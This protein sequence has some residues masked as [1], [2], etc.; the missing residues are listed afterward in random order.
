MSKSHY[1]NDE[2]IKILQDFYKEHSRSPMMKDFKNK[3]PSA[4]LIKC[5][6]GSWNNALK[7][8][9]LELNKTKKEIYT[10]QQLLDFLKEFYELYGYVPT[11]R[12]LTNKGYPTFYAYKKHFGSFKNALIEAGLFDL[13]ED[14]HQFCE[15]YTDEELLNKLRQFMKG[16]DYIPTY[17]EMRKEL[18]PSVSTYD[19]RFNGVFNALKLI[20]YDVDK[21]KEKEVKLIEQ[22]MIEKYK[23]L[24]KMLGRT[25]TSRDVDRY[26]KEGLCYAMSTYSNHF[27]SLYKLQILCG[28]PPTVS[29]R[30]KTKDEMINDIIKIS[31]I[32]GKTPSRNDLKF[33]DG[34]ASASKYSAVFGSWSK[35]VEEA[36]L[37]PNDDFYYAINGEK[38]LSYYELL[39]NN[40]LCTYKIKYKKEE[41]YKKYIPT[42]KGY[43]FDFVI[44]FN[45]E[46]YFIEIFGITNSSNYNRKIKDKINLCKQYN[47]K[48][49]E[50][51]PD[52]FKS[53]KYDYLYNMLI[54][55]I[56][57]LK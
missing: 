33:F 50:I 37:Q 19:R 3:E 17:D 32:L 44:D 12:D 8:A 53:Y 24:A 52:D 4:S 11:H 45:N 46:K 14:K 16:R 36:G 29:G 22:D 54:D 18:S 35:A 57:N 30:N 48:L 25:P 13:R 23:K 15:E 34:V 51:Y 6:F 40:M 38:C 31:K 10:K 47:L 7:K 26:S 2:L 20:G 21:Q 39:F 9:G 49:V 27:G 41:H 56:N 28:L 1:T 43:R 42:K 55:K 5:R